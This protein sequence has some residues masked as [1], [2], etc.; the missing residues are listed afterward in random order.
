[1]T[2]QRNKYLRDNYKSYTLRLNVKTDNRIIQ[3]LNQVPNQ[4]RYIVDLIQEDLSRAKK[5]MATFDDHR[6][7]LDHVRR[8]PFE[9]LDQI[10]TGVDYSVGFAR[11]LEDAKILLINY[12]NREGNV[13]TISIIRRTYDE[14]RREIVGRIE[15]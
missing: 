6:D 14:K 3:R 5:Y 1:M 2:E 7:D 4:T 10:R 12:V 8:F 11:D 13:G 15:R 9:V